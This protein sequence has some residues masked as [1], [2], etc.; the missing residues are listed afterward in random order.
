[1]I[2]S[3]RQGN[4]ENGI[5]AQE[6][7]LSAFTFFVWVLGATCV[8][9]Q[10]DNAKSFLDEKE[11][12]EAFSAIVRSERLDYGFDYPFLYDVRGEEAEVLQNHPSVWINDEPSERRSIRQAME[13]MGFRTR[14]VWVHICEIRVSNDQPGFCMIGI[15]WENHGQNSDADSLYTALEFV[16][17][18]RCDVLANQM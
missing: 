15:S 8:Y 17:G 14:S 13:T 12:F 2:K 6:H 11:C 7:A 1:M 9:P 4:L 18:D 5:L 3:K 10:T 16:A